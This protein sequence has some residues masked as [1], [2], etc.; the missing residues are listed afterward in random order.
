MCDA[1]SILFNYFHIVFHCDATK[2]P[3]TQVMF[4]R[5]TG[6]G[7][8]CCERDVMD[9]IG[10]VCNFMDECL[11]DWNCHIKRKRTEFYFLNHFTTAQLVILR[12][13]VHSH[14]LLDVLYLSCKVAKVYSVREM[15][16]VTMCT[17]VLVIQLHIDV[18]ISTAMVL[19]T[20]MIGMNLCRCDTLKLNL[21][22]F[23]SH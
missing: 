9:Q 21:C 17:S 7:K 22:T 4:G 19:H 18:I 1:G 3:N 8:F 5:S 2:D 23:S 14:I 11:D 15:R 13:E 20:V 10:E 6:L 16:L 12:K